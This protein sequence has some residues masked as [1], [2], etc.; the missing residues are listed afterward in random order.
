MNSARVSPDTSSPTPVNATGTLSARAVAFPLTRSQLV[1]LALTAIVAVALTFRMRD[2]H[3]VG[4]GVAVDVA[5]VRWG[6][7]HTVIRF[8]G[9]ISLPAADG[10]GECDNRTHIPEHDRIVPAVC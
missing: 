1:T 8:C 10:Q 3:L 2:A 6:S 9:R 7:R 4:P 5:F